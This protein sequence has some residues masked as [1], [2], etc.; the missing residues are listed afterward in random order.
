[1]RD[2]YIL[3]RCPRNSESPLQVCEVCFVRGF[4]LPASLRI[5]KEKKVEMDD[6]WGH[7]YD[8]IISRVYEKGE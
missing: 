6:K 3:I 2:N 8:Y 7:V 1:M 4:D 5:V